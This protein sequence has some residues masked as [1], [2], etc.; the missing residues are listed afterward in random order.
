MK[1]LFSATVLTGAL[2]FASASADAG[3]IRF[4]GAVTGFADLGGN[5]VASP[6]SSFAVGDAFSGVL[7]VADEALAPGA[8]FGNADIRD[9]RFS[10]GDTALTN[11]R[12]SLAG[13]LGPNGRGLD[14]F[15][16]FTGISALGPACSFC[17]AEIT[18]DG[19]SIDHFTAGGRILG[20]LTA[21]VERGATDVPAPGGLLGLMG[22]AMIGTLARVRGRAIDG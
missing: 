9:Y 19:F 4:S 6:V 21:S 14:D 8:T 16:A 11:E 5:P 17:S 22:L 12:T 1:R 3:M 10:V 2:L 18:E 15:L 13:T 20:D 7:D